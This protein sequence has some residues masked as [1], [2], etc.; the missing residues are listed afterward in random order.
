MPDINLS[1]I[2]KKFQVLLK[3]IR[4]LRDENKKLNIQVQGGIE[5]IQNQ[6]QH[7]TDLE[8]KIKMLKM[9]TSSENNAG[10]ETELRKEIRATL[11][12]YIHEIDSCIALLNK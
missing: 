5:E 7:I 8:E 4:F 12:S 10:T 6:Q 2:D 1:H 9:I 3:Q 11:N